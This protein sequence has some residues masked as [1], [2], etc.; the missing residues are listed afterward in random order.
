VQ[1]RFTLHDP[2]PVRLE[3]LDAQGRVLKGWRNDSATTGEHAV[4]WDFHDTQ[5]RSL[6][7]GCY[8]VRLRVN[9]S[10]STRAFARIP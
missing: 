10:T 7:A 4:T 5:G 3:V 2:A 6:P 1:L 9:G 8:F